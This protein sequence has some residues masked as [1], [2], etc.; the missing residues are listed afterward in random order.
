MYE[1]VVRFRQREEVMEKVDSLAI[2]LTR[3]QAYQFQG[4]TAYCRRAVRRAA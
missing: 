4:V 2:A 1:I 3:V